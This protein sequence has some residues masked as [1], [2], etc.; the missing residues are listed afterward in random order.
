MARKRLEV[1][2][3]ALQLELSATEDKNEQ[4][5]A[6][7]RAR[8]AVQTIISDADSWMA[9][10]EWDTQITRILRKKPHTLKPRRMSRTDRIFYL[11]VILCAWI[12]FV[13]SLLF[14]TSLAWMLIHNDN[15]LGALL[16][17][18]ATAALAV[19]FM[20]GYATFSREAQKIKFPKADAPI[21][22]EV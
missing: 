16:T 9:Y 20:W 21:F 12:F 8:Q 2:G 7:L 6:K 1:R 13:I 11:L 15:S 4:E 5:Q 17:I 19:A 14:F 3:Q 18:A 22:D 10:L